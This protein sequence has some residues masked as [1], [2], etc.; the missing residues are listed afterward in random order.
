MNAQMLVFLKALGPLL[1]LIYINDLCTMFN[2]FMYTYDTTLICDLNDIR[3]ENQSTFLNLELEKVSNWLAK[4][5][6]NTDTI[7]FMVFRKKYR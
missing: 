6:L 4:Q 5:S 7:K 3:L 1:F 2:V